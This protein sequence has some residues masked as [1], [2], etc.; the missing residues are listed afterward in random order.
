MNYLQ[1]QKLFSAEEAIIAHYISI[2]YKE[3]IKCNHCNSDKV[4]Q[5]KDRPKFFYCS[6]CINHFSVFKDTIFEHSSTDMR[7]WFYAIHLF[8]NGKKGISGC[9]LQRE[10][11]V[12]YKTAWRMLQQIRKAMGNKEVQQS[13]EAI[14]EIDETYVGGKPK[15]NFNKDNKNKRGRGTKKS[16]VVGVID[17]QNKQV[18]AKVALPNKEGKKLTGKQLLSI[19]N[20]VVKQ[21]SIVMTDE[22]KS[23]NILSKTEHIH[24][25]VDHTKE[26]VNGL[27]HTNNIESFW[28]TLKRG[29]YGIYHSVSTKYLQNY[30]NEFCFRYNNRDVESMFDLLL[31]QSINI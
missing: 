13:F 3:G 1:F 16:P 2:R 5:V 31:L 4:Y 27:I 15:K 28:A 14:V 24:L 29:I 30:V 21:S 8:L 20:E 17:R 6:H 25:K 18:H 22:F 7:K 11:D 9:Q 19:L 23:Y 26:Y 10:I 12:T